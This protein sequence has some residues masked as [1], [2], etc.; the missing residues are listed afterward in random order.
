MNENIITIR[1]EIDDLNC[2]YE[3]ES[4]MIRDY[5]ADTLADM[6][7]KFNIFLKQAGFIRK[8][9]YIFMEDVTEEEYEAIGD[10]LHS[11]RQARANGA[12]SS[13]SSNV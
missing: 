2:H 9:D 4:T 1:F 13:A 8:N 7:E 12:T 5:G 6:G 11:Y 3:A 10:F